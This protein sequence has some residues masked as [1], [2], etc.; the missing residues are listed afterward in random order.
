MIKT[1]CI[2]GPGYRQQW[3]SARGVLRCWPAQRKPP[4][5]SPGCSHV[6]QVTNTNKQTTFCQTQ[7]IICYYIGSFTRQK[8]SNLASEQS[9]RWICL[10][11]GPTTAHMAYFK[12]NLL[13][14]SFTY[15][16]T[17]SYSIQPYKSWGRGTN[18]FKQILS[19][20]RN[21]LKK[22]RGILKIGTSL[23]PDQWSCMSTISV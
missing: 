22:F 16:M 11:S 7:S 6:Y 17:Q 5:I 4:L 23:P 2:T 18:L 14:L 15:L 13:N 1:V 19:T 8:F 20:N 3:L 9:K 12:A 21:I 10:G